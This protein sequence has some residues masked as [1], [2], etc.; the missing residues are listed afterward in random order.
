MTYIE[1]KDCKYYLGDLSCLAFEKIPQDI[2]EGE[3][4]HEVR[5]HQDVDVFFEEGNPNDLLEL[6]PPLT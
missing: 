1:C 5:K 4:H 6:E 2:L 3:P